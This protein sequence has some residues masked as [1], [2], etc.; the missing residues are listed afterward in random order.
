MSDMKEWA[1]R[2]IEL[3]CK[4]ERG[5][6]D[7]NEWDYGVACYESAFKAFESLMMDEHSEYSIYATMSILNRLVQCKPL[8]PIEDTPDIWHECE[9]T[10]TGYAKNLQCS[11]MGSFWKDIYPDGTVEYIDNDRVVTYHIDH[12]TIVWHNGTITHLIHE[13]FPITMPYYPE[14]TPYKVYIYEGLDTVAVFY[15]IKPNGERVDINRYFDVTGDIREI[16]KEEYQEREKRFINNGH[17]N[18][19]IK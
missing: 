13:M 16:T 4:R 14:S 11:R 6:K 2:E 17:E 1:K 19:M 12:P 10:N 5:D 7:P 8:T 9:F 3:A 15:V 18:F